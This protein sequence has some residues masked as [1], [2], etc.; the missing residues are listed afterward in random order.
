V[1]NSPALIVFFVKSSYSLPLAIVQPTA[2]TVSSMVLFL[3]WTWW[4]PALLKL[5]SRG[6][7]AAV[8]DVE[9]VFVGGG[10][11]WVH[12]LSV[13][14]VTQIIKTS[15]FNTNICI[16]VKSRHLVLDTRNH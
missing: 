9:R 4:G 2:S 10:E 1:L 3:M 16:R 15:R 8:R 13:K 11:F 14:N 6:G 7:V 5:F 12:S